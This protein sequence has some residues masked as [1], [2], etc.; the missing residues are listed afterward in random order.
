MEKQ[1]SEAFE[2]PEFYKNV[3]FLIKTKEGV[4]LHSSRVQKLEKGLLKLENAEQYAL[5]SIEKGD[6]DCFNCA[7]LFYTNKRITLQKN[8][9]WKYGVTELGQKERG[10]SDDWLIENS[11]KYI[12]Q[13]QGNI[14]KC[15]VEERKNIFNYALLPENLERKRP[16]IRPPGN[17]NDR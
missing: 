3:K 13:F 12:I 11:L 9:V 10:Y 6:F 8:D 16:I 17:K 15:L 2:K 5:K 4:K 1:E 14:K 7:A